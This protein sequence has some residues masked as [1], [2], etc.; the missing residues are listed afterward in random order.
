MPFLFYLL[1]CLCLH[2]VLICILIL[3]LLMHHNFFLYIYFHSTSF[4]V[5]DSSVFLLYGF[6]LLSVFWCYKFYVRVYAFTLSSV[7]FDALYC[8]VCLTF[9]PCV[10][11]HLQ[12]LFIVMFEY[13]KFFYFSLC[14]QVY[15]YSWLACYISE[16]SKDI[17]IPE[18]RYVP[19]C[20][21][22]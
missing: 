15:L 8:A 4:N 16:K 11:T 6:I 20:S 3:Q 12:C 14:A 13:R 21:V 2:F 9:W 19:C 17:F 1:L 18:T 22:I 7:W 10:C 5:G